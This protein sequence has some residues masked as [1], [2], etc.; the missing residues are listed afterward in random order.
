[1][2]PD[3]GSGI[4]GVKWDDID[5]DFVSGTFIFVL[6][7]PF[8][9]TQVTAGFK[10]GAGIGFQQIAGPLCA[11]TPTPTPAVLAEE[12]PPRTAPDALPDTG[13]VGGTKSARGLPVPLAFLALGL[14]LM[15]VILARRVR[16]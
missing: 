3:P 5:S 8:P 13:G 15:I 16:N 10:T 7:R 9:T 1:V 6:D 12:A 4:S 2:D 14:V 11:P